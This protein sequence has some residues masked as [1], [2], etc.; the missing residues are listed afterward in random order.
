MKNLHKHTGPEQAGDLE[1]AYAQIKDATL[2][3][4]TQGD[5]VLFAFETSELLKN[6]LY[7]PGLHLTTVPFASCIFSHFILTLGRGAVRARC[8]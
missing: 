1:M 3:D 7:L 4:I 5:F 8:R 6:F 2:V